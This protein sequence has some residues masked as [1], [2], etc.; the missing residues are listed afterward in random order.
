MISFLRG[1]IHHFGLDYLLID[2][3]GVGYRVSFFHPDK[4]SIGQEMLIYTYD[5][6]REDERT[7]YGFLTIDEYD[8]FVKLI[9]VKGLGPK[10]ASNILTVASVEALTEAI[11]NEDLQFMRNM[12]GIGIKTA[13]QIILD[14]KGKL[15]SE[16]NSD[17]DDEILVDV[18]EALKNLGYKPSEI[19]PVLKE[20]SKEPG[21]SADEYLKRALAMFIK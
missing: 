17:V 8:M 19:K 10:I 14:L 5:N 18:L 1:T 9:S 15:V 16:D 21:L 11:Q 6:V 12:P 7:L 2:V 13:S 4:L 20:L 3:N